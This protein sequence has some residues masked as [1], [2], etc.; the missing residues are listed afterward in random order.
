MSPEAE[1]P[2]Q[3]A[4]QDDNWIWPQAEHRRRY[5][6]PF[7]REAGKAT[8]VG[9]DPRTSQSQQWKLENRRRLN[10]K[11]CHSTL[12]RK[13]SGCCTSKYIRAQGTFYLVW[14]YWLM[15]MKGSLYAD[16]T[17]RAFPHSDTYSFFQQAW[18]LGTTVPILYLRKIKMSLV[19]DT[20][21]M[22]TR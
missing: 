10:S 21:H 15:F 14:K 2:G 7:R 20:E 3:M 18:E 9:V 13:E 8:S 16:A 5:S 1:Q 4:E 17:L 22:R 11:R 19:H 12:M 6:G